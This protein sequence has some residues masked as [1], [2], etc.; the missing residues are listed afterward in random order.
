MFGGTFTVIEPEEPLVQLRFVTVVVAPSVDVLL[1]VI[2]SS[3]TNKV[4]GHRETK[5][6][7]LCLQV[8]L[9]D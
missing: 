7:D 1:I 6:T 4:Y 9:Q 8:A 3:V 5:D 2:V